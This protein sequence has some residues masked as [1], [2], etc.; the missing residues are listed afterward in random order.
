MNLYKLF[1]STLIIFSGINSAN[2]LIVESTN[3]RNAAPAVLQVRIYLPLSDGTCEYNSDN[4]LVYVEIPHEKS[5]E[6]GIDDENPN[7]VL[8]VM[9]YYGLQGN[10]AKAKLYSYKDKHNCKV[11]FYR[12]SQGNQTPETPVIPKSECKA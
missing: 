1:L 9:G 8:C 6:V 12:E 2:A 7:L 11:E 4:D 3:P 5:I 10:N